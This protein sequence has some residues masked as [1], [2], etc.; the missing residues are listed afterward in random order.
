KCLG[1]YMPTAV[2]RVLQWRNDT[3]VALDQGCDLW[4]RWEKSRD[5]VANVTNRDL[6]QLT[7]EVWTVLSR[8]AFN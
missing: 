3:P 5:G 4:S 6:N 1:Q 2:K 7:C 8:G